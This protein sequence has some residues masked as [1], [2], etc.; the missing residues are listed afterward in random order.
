[1]KVNLEKEVYST[2]FLHKNKAR[3][4]GRRNAD[5]PLEL[6]LVVKLY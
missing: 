6:I 1:M 4:N 2:E 5:H 3:E